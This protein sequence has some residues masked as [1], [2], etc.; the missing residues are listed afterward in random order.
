M[1]GPKLPP[2][3]LRCPRKGQVIAGRC[4]HGCRSLACK[5]HHF[6]GKFLPFKTPLD[7]RYDSQIP[8]ADRFGV[9]MLI[10]SL[11]AKQLKIGLIIDLTKTTRFYD[12]AEL[13]D[14]SIRQYKLSCEGYVRRRMYVCGGAGWPNS[15]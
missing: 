3:W 12:K 7:G 6:L 13:V 15:T 5:C 4:R 1:S 2:R 9:K 8:E 14:L 11:A 10:D